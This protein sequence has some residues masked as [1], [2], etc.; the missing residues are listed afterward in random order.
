MALLQIR[1]IHHCSLNG[2]P[3]SLSHRLDE[4]QDAPSRWKQATFRNLPKKIKQAAKYDYKKQ[5]REEEMKVKI[6]DA[7]QRRSTQ[8]GSRGGRSS[9]T[10]RNSVIAGKGVDKITG[11]LGYVATTVQDDATMH[12][13]SSAPNRPLSVP[14]AQGTPQAL[15]DQSSPPTKGPL[16]SPIAQGAPPAFV[17]HYPLPD[18]SFSLDSPLSP[19]PESDFSS[20]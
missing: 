11:H 13:I 1:T 7:K 5:G 12:S 8:G 10:G 15:M 9:N 14:V 16:S 6:R 2:K 3:Y 17:G 18:H 19:H 4:L 20:S